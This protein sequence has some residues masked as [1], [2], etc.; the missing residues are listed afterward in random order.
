MVTFVFLLL[1]L[2]SLVGASR[3]QTLTA[4]NNSGTV[5]PGQSVLGNTIGLFVPS[6]DVVPTSCGG[7]KVS[8]AMVFY[9][10]AAGSSGE[11]MATTCSE[12]TDFDT[13]LTVYTLSGNALACVH[14]N[15]DSSSC[16][17]GQSAVSFTADAGSQYVIG[18]GGFN[19]EEGNFKLGL[20]DSGA[21]T[22]GAGYAPC[23]QAS[24]LTLPTGSVLGTTAGQPHPSQSFVG[25]CGGPVH[26]GPASWYR[27]PAGTSGRFAVSTCASETEFDT[28][29]TVYTGDCSAA[30]LSCVDGNDDSAEAQCGRK[31]KVEFT[32]EADKTY[33]ILIGGYK[34]TS[35][36]FRLT[37][38][39]LSGGVDE[40]TEEEEEEDETTTT[41]SGDGM[42]GCSSAVA[43]TSFPHTFVGSTAAA[44][45]PPAGLLAKCGG[46]THSG[47]A[48][49]FKMPADSVG[50]FRATTCFSQT[51]FDSQL[52]VYRGTCDGGFTCVT[53]NDDA[54]NTAC[55]A[56]AAVKFTVEAGQGPYYVLVHG[57]RDEA[58][59]VG[60]RITQEDLIED[61]ENDD[62][63]EDNSG[64]TQRG[65]ASCVSA[66]EITSFPATVRGSTAGASTPSQT[67]LPKCGSPVH[68]GPATWYKL[69]RQ[70][71][72]YVV[73][74]CGSTLG[75][76]SQLTV[77]TGSCTDTTMTCVTG[78]DDASDSSCGKASTVAFDATADKDYYVIVHGYK[79][80]AGEFTLRAAFTA[81]R[82]SDASVSWEMHMDEN[83]GR[84]HTNRYRSA[85]GNLQQQ[86]LIVRRAQ[87]LV[88][89]VTGEV[90]AFELRLV[91]ATPADGVLT[92]NIAHVRGR[93]H[94][95]S[96][97][98]SSSAPVGQYELVALLTNGK[99]SV[100]PVNVVILFNA[101]SP[102]SPVYMP[103]NM[104]E[105]YL[106]KE[107]GGIWKGSTNDNWPIEWSFDQ[108]QVHNLIVSIR[109]LQSLTIDQRRDPVLVARRLSAMLNANQD[110]GVL[111]GR[112]KD[113]FPNGQQPGYWSSST[114]IMDQYNRES[115]TVKYG[116]CWVF[117]GIFTTA[118]RTLG[119]PARSVTKFDSGHERPRHEGKFNQYL[120]KYY[121]MNS[122]GE[123]AKDAGGDSI[124]NYHVW[125]DVW[126]SRPDLGQGH[127]WQAVDATPQE[128]SV[129]P[130]QVNF[131]E[132]INQCGP[133]SLESM[134]QGRP[135]DKYDADFVMGEVHGIEQLWI[136]FASSDQYQKDSRR[137][138]SLATSIK[139]MRH[140]CEARLLRTCQEELIRSDYRLDNHAAVFGGDMLLA[141]EDEPHADVQFTASGPESVATGEPIAAELRAALSGTTGYTVNMVVTAIM[142]SSKGEEL[143]EAG[144]VRHMAELG[145]DGQ[146]T[147]KVELTL[148]DDAYG[149]DGG[150]AKHLGSTNFVLLRFSGV[151]MSK[152]ESHLVPFVEEIT[153]TLTPINPQ[154]TCSSA[155][156]QDETVM[157][158]LTVNNPLNLDLTEV[159]LQRHVS[160][161]DPESLGAE[162]LTV[163]NV[164]AK[165]DRTWTNIPIKL[166]TP[167]DKNIIIT[168]VCNELT[169]VTA[170]API[171]VAENHA[172]PADVEGAIVT[173]VDFKNVGEEPAPADLLLVAPFKTSHT[174][175]PGYVPRG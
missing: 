53:G 155:G 70:T 142:V 85:T 52:T 93:G 110:N 95:Y 90:S 29:L 116:Q 56:R 164:P 46:P 23:E 4:I 83:M 63:E 84:A 158:S 16:S 25:K 48:V 105:G 6:L 62:N 166:L 18:V 91:H 141:A 154:L 1:C 33:Y 38:E 129:G 87:S 17:S 75:W 128:K 115:A 171:Q 161:Q 168:V 59:S 124:W 57:F 40:T 14:G 108:Y 13:Q 125:N 21:S 127:G 45:T 26:T 82:D 76:D 146:A 170:S 24:E 78:N 113:T 94:T 131:N 7:P 135:D 126:M 153:T 137:P 39:Q 150:I 106:E 107:T 88:V 112:W 97:S 92:A 96:L 42:A 86:F 49:W 99:S 65:H 133:A 138:R 167:G 79:Q 37:Y 134:T 136:R 9:R 47:P 77:Y 119:V 100:A 98:L 2:V 172:R 35:G 143:G 74:T 162:S 20:K 44:A 130:M 60:M 31:S 71:G 151:A 132:K 149:A 8:G 5:A 41:S 114:A 160:G 43:V 67:L 55:G 109:L 175:R 165:G 72:K 159:S 22:G 111:T 120:D 156:K 89:D 30:S 102:G 68:S 34:D 169:D 51:A 174:G 117:S 140:D 121:T 80:E 3:E 104:R 66:E 81:T 12:D 61:V 163:R 101:Y 11:L 122:Q 15:D 27:L 58:G 73:S 54:A 10:V 148:G 147:T 123:W 152:D 173:E 118:M 144:T 32:A 28:Q 69:P 157:C 36:T 64:P 145:P 19:K 50:L 103:T 139:T